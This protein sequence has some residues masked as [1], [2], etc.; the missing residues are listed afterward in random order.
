MNAITDFHP[1][2]GFASDSP[3]VRLLKKTLTT[4]LKMY[5]GETTFIL[6]VISEPCQVVIS[7]RQKQ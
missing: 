6:F 3:K 1:S 2:L 5:V 7:N 4:S